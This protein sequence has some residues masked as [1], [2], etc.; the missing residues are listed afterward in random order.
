MHKAELGFGL[1]VCLLCCCLRQRF[2][3]SKTQTSVN[4][5]VQLGLVTPYMDSNR[6]VKP[7]PTLISI[8][9][10]TIPF[11]LL[12]PILRDKCNI[13]LF[14]LYP[15]P[16]DMCTITLLL[17]YP[18]PKDMCTNSLL[19][20]NQYQEIC[21]LILSSYLTSTQKHVN[22]SSPPVLYPKSRDMCTIPF[23]LLYPKP[24]NMC[25]NPL[26]LFSNLYSSLPTLFSTQ[27][28]VF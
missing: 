16:R 4:L 11:V 21:V 7:P 1:C 9:I 19:L 10:C 23:I 12:Y 26:F 2:G 27:R 15:V 13:P 22:F 14:L 17:L 24:R 3:I 25:T 8:N 6:L 18:V 5:V 20:S 28:Y